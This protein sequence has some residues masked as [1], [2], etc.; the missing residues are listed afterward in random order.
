ME[1]GKKE[2]K[3]VTGLQRLAGLL[4][5]PASSIADVTHM[6]LEGNSQVRIENSSGILEYDSERIC[7]KTGKLITE[8]TGRNLKIKCLSMEIMEI[9]G[10]LTGIQFVP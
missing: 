9:H 3:K 7:I 10:F 4:E 2:Q 1:R 8:F 5:I 6:E